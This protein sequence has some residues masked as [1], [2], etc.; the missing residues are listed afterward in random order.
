MGSVPETGVHASS[1]PGS[2]PVPQMRRR[3]CSRRSP[4]S[5]SW[6]KP[7]PSARR[8]IAWSM[9]FG[10]W[11]QSIT[12]W[13]ARLRAMTWC[14]SRRWRRARSSA[15]WRWTCRSPRR[16]A[17]WAW[18]GEQPIGAS[19]RP[20]T[21]WASAGP[22]KPWRVPGSSAGWIARWER[23]SEDAAAGTQGPARGGG[24][25]RTSPAAMVAR[26]DGVLHHRVNGSPGAHRTRR[27]ADRPRGGP[28]RGSS[29]G[30]RRRSGHRQ[31]GSRPNRNCR[32]RSS[33]LGRRRVRDPVV[34]PVPPTP[35]GARHRAV[36]RSRRR[37][38][39]RRADRRTRRSV[40][41]RHPVGRRADARDP[42]SW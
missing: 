22:P 33:W 9:T 1:A 21:L 4:G 11:D 27:G 7:A 16:R 38:D 40:P 18:P 8:S 25:Y 23:P 13:L 10:G 34:A 14:P 26:V 39:D 32:S 29:R 35:P 30:A 5:A 12:A 42:G 15:C 3:P 20:V 31:D 37:R 2:S 36:G 24:P 19:R 41:R 6:W 28:G 17:G